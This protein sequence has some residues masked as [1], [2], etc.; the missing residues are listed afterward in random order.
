VSQAVPLA[1]RPKP[2]GA[3]LTSSFPVAINE[4]SLILFALSK[5]AFRWTGGD[6]TFLSPSPVAIRFEKETGCGLS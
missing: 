4:A 5:G 3:T 1:G 6:N 2:S